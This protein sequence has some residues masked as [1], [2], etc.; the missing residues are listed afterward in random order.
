MPLIPLLFGARPDVSSF[1]S[2]RL[3]TSGI[4]FFVSPPSSDQR[5]RPSPSD[6]LISSGNAPSSCPPP[7][8][9]SGRPSDSRLGWTVWAFFVSQQTYRRL[10]LSRAGEST[11]FVISLF[12]RVS[13]HRSSRQSHPATTC[14]NNHSSTESFRYSHPGLCSLSY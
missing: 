2:F 14:S 10:A 3:G 4:E 5:V 13:L 11:V 9:S 1:L 12:A 6:A 8:T 7:P